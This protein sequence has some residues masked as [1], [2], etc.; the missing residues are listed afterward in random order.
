MGVTVP[1]QSPQWLW[2]AFASR[3]APPDAAVFGIG[4]TIVDPA[5][6]AF[7]ARV[8]GAVIAARYETLGHFEHFTPHG[9]RLAPVVRLCFASA[10]PENSAVSVWFDHP[11]RGPIEVHRFETGSARGE[12]VADARAVEPG[13]EGGPPAPP[14]PSASPGSEPR[15]W[16][17]SLGE[18]PWIVRVEGAPARVELAVGPCVHSGS[19]DLREGETRVV[20]ALD[21]TLVERAHITLRR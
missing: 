14:S 18:G 10:L 11:E 21:R 17:F 4:G 9:P 20:R 7:S 1:D 2:P 13:V 15:S 6:V 3:E 12:R 16:A 8:A 5:S 19:A